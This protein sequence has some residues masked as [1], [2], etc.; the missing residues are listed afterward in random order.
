MIARFA[1]S[2]RTEGECKN[3]EVNK[4]QDGR[5][6]QGVFKTI[7]KPKHIIIFLLSD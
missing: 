5:K 7:I 2:P 3:K 4:R 6:E 1:L